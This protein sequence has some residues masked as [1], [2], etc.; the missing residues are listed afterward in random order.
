M[1]ITPYATLIKKLNI[2]FVECQNDKS[3]TV[4][5]NNLNKDIIPKYCS[6]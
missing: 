2:K 5:I 6:V 4:P 1:V 3:H